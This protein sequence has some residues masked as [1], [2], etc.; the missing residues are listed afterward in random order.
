MSFQQSPTTVIKRNLVKTK[1]NSI[2]SLDSRGTSLNA[3]LFLHGFSENSEGWNAWSEHH[4]LMSERWQITFP[5]IQRRQSG[6]LCRLKCILNAGNLEQGESFANSVSGKRISKGEG[7]RKYPENI[8]DRWIVVG[9]NRGWRSHQSESGLPDKQLLHE[10]PRSDKSING[11]SKETM[12]AIVALRQLVPGFE[13][14]KLR[15][16]DMT[17][18]YRDSRKIIGRYNLTEDDV[19]NRTKF[20]DSIGIFPEFIDGYNIIILPTTGRY[21]EASYGCLLPLELDNLLVVGGSAAGHKT[22]H[23]AV[24]LKQDISTKKIDIELVQKELLC[25]GVG[26]HWNFEREESGMVKEHDPE[27]IS[28]T[29]LVWRHEGRQNKESWQKN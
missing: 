8:G 5:T 18:G 4:I 22:S 12:H 28:D 7:I 29:F 24:S 3:D 20:D 1:F 17:L 15:N 2:F 14:A 21:F 10:C 16:F 13:T 11:R 23:V 19:K 26:L 27:Y 25:Q 9:V 6:K